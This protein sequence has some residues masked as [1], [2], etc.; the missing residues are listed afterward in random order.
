MNIHFILHASFESPAAIQTWAEQKGHR[1]SSTKVYEKETVPKSA[2]NIDFLIVMGGP[3]SPSTTLTECP[4]FDAEKEINLIKSAITHKKLILGVCLGAQL[5][6]EAYG[7]RCI[8]SP[9]R[10][11]GVFPVTLTKHAQRDP[12]FS[13]FPQL[14]NVG[15]WHGD[16]PGI[17]DDSQILAHSEG[18]PRQV[19]K[20]SDR[21]YGFQCHFEF[22]PQAIEAMIVHCSDDLKEGTF[23]QN[24]TK[25]KTNDYSEM[26]TLLYQFLDHMESLYLQK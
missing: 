5:L 8:R 6:G 15:H 13:Q 25:L 10:E 4:Y 22:T 21:I 19:V 18:C 20:Y 2:E 16:M 23:I 11:I 3:Q 1:I 9:H 14:F 7:A 17:I 26:N 24:S 12:I